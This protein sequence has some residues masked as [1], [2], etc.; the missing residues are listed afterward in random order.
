M[1]GRGHAADSIVSRLSR[2]KLR[3]DEN[4]SG[5]VFLLGRLVSCRPELPLR[6]RFVSA[7]VAG[8]SVSRGLNRSPYPRRK[9]TGI[10]KILSDEAPLTALAAVYAPLLSGSTVFSSRL[11]GL[12]SR[13][14]RQIG[15]LDGKECDDP[16]ESE[17]WV[18][19]LTLVESKT[20]VDG[21][22]ID[23]DA[24]PSV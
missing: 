12:R 3:P 20:F 17:E 21:G 7:P 16:R 15:P 6:S 2:K 24:S 8:S 13:G 18:P 19:N 11:A 9:V 23:C 14:S 4:G 1:S 10:E 5:S 22:W